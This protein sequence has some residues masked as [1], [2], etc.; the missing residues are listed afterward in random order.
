[1][2]GLAGLIWLPCLMKNKG[3]NFDVSGLRGT[4]QTQQSCMFLIIDPN[5]AELSSQQMAKIRSSASD[6]CE[7]M[8]EFYLL[9]KGTY[10]SN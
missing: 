4:C 7:D 1:M 3:A 10:R 5:S 8:Q 6:V 9:E 2:L